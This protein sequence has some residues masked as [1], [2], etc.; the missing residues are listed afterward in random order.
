MITIVINENES[1]DSA[2]RRLRRFVEKSGLMKELR[3]R[4][5]FEKPSKKKQRESVAAKKREIKRQKL[6]FFQDRL[7]K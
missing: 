5:R 1:I 6:F 7:K 3:Q 4:E 2:I